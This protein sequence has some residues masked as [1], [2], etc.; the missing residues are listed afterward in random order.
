MMQDAFAGKNS[1]AEKL[2]LWYIPLAFAALF[3]W[4]S[5]KKNY[6]Y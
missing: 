6:K 3:I 2:V 1:T 4:G 5:V